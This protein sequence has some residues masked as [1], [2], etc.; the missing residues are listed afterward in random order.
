[1]R[2]RRRTV[3]K[4][5]RAAARIV[6]LLSGF[7]GVGL[8]IICLVVSFA[9]IGAKVNSTASGQT[10][11][12][13][14]TSVGGPGVQVFGDSTLTGLAGKLPAE[15]AGGKVSADVKAG[16]TAQ[17]GE[18]TLNSVPDTAP[19][20]FVISLAEDDTSTQ[21][22]Y[23][24][25]IDEL[26]LMLSGRT[27]Y[28]VTAP[29][30]DSYTKIV[31]AENLAN[32]SDP[33]TQSGWQIVDFAAA[34]KQHADWWSGGKPTDAGLSGL[35]KTLT[36]YLGA[37]RT[38]SDGGA[39]TGDITV[40]STTNSTDSFKLDGERLF[41]A[42]TIVSVGTGMGVPTR[43]LVIA[44]ATA[45]Q[46]SKF[47]NIRGGRAGAYGLFQQT[48]T[49]GWGTVAQVMDPTY[50]ATAF[51]AHLQR[52]SGWQDMALTDAAQAVQRSGYPGAYAQWEQSAMV[53]VAALTGQHATGCGPQVDR[54]GNPRAQIAVNAVLSQL[55]VPYT[56]AGGNLSG[57]TLGQ[58]V[59]GTDGSNDC[60]VVG[61]DCSGLMLYAWGKA[62]VSVPHLTGAMWTD[63]RFTHITDKSQ[64]QPGDMMMFEGSPPG[65]TGMY[66]GN[67]K[68]VDAPHSGAVVEIVSVDEPSYKSGYVGALRPKV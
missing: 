54:P 27:V 15:L 5:A 25:R 11:C 44:V 28:W 41:N 58:C 22:A 26:M 47:V 16:R 4:G 20:T 68:V 17:Q 33:S 13:L 37:G 6:K 38:S 49:R 10:S 53:I 14:P 50:A 60:H 7:G 2:M 23:T 21:P 64:L 24:A 29:G 34:V 35:A 8:F 61:F 63:P 40:T 59:A 48:P 12:E 42:R 56:F 19:G 3:P 43:G 31:T 45:A 39:S 36:G 62:G 18:N 55:G 65:H 32:P 57:P 52:I 30:K 51:Y 46:E 1:M 66:I 9:A 67:G